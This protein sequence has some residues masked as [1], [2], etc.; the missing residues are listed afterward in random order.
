MYP[1]FLYP[2]VGANCIRPTGT[3]P[4]SPAS[5]DARMQYAPTYSLPRRGRPRLA[6]AHEHLEV[7]EGGGGGSECPVPFPRGCIKMA[8]GLEYT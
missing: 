7:E 2:V 4:N 6:S 3:R 1:A 8:V 5:V